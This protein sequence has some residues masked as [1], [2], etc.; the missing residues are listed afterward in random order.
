MVFPLV[1]PRVKQRHNLTS[2]QINRGNVAAFLTVAVKAGIARIISGGRSPMFF[3]DDMVNFMRHK[4]IG[5]MQQAVFAATTGPFDDL[6]PQGFGDIS[7]LS[8]SFL[9]TR[10]FSILMK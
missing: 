2:F 1:A 8:A 4:V 3:S 7:H 6:S 10:I 9:R 5:V